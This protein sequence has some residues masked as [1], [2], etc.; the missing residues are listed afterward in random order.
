MPGP[1][2][3]NRAF[4]KRAVL[5]CVATSFITTFM[6]SALNLAV[7]A[8]GSELGARAA[9]AGWI[10]TVY[11]LACTLL[12]IPLGLLA[13]RKGKTAVLRAGI[14]IFAASS[15]AAAF[16]FGL[17]PALL[18][19]LM[20]GAGAAMIFCANV[21]LL[22][23]AFD[24][25]SRGRALGIAAC[26][27]YAGLA[28]GP[29]IGGFLNRALGWRAIFVAAAV[30]ALLALAALGRGKSKR[31]AQRDAGGRKSGPGRLW[32]NRVFVLSG[33]AAFINYGSTF[34][35]S[36]LTSVYLQTVVGLDSG[37]AGLILLG[38]PVVLTAI[39]PAAGRLSDKF[40]PRLLSAA[41]M[42]ICAAALAMLGLLQADGSLTY[43]VISLV[44][45]GTGQGL[46]SSPNVNAVTSSV[47]ENDHALAVSVL[48]TLRS[49]GH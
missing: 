29:V 39:S 31:Q 13:A 11:V 48:A 46:F 22:V 14:L 15:A 44:L 24:E 5:T 45:A 37:K 34:I 26:A 7:P 40:S 2:R 9:S 18:C 28:A 47:E 6:G 23:E 10:I 17:A 20:Q 19:R 42:A 12:T 3:E 27:N 43:V 33:L 32:K 49:A 4:Q 30:V 36:Y 8:M 16:S 21:P 25:G 35:I 1:G 38:S 41:G